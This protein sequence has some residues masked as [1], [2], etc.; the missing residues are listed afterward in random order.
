M[1]QSCEILRNSSTVLIDTAVSH[2][3]RCSVAGCGNSLTSSGSFNVNSNLTPLLL[4]LFFISTYSTCG[5]PER[6]T[7]TLSLVPVTAVIPTVLCQTC[8]LL[9]K[10]RSVVAHNMVRRCYPAGMLQ[11][12]AAIFLCSVAPASCFAP[13]LPHVGNAAASFALTHGESRWTSSVSGPRRGCRTLRCSIS[14]DEAI[15]GFDPLGF[16]VNTS[17]GNAQ[18]PLHVPDLQGRRGAARGG[19]GAA[20]HSLHAT[21]RSIA[22]EAQATRRRRGVTEDGLHAIK[23]GVAEVGVVYTDMPLEEEDGGSSGVVKGWDYWKYRALLLGVALLWGTNFPAVS[24]L[25]TLLV[26]K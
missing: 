10:S 15:H 26:D 1:S 2:E 17:A 18:G 11:S 14:R 19:K 4:F 6:Q 12:G 23:R 5:A 8:T 24:G 21:K 13:R 20:R 3:W 9:T 16:G 7:N 22:D 25:S